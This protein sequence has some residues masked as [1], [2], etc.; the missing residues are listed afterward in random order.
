MAARQCLLVAAT[1]M[2][3]VHARRALH[4]RFDLVSAFS[5]HQALASL[6]S[7]GIDAIVCSI[8]FDESRM[9]DLLT[10]AR[11]L[12]PDTPVVCCRI[13]HSPLSPRAIEALITTVQSLGCR[14][15]VDFN[16]LYR[17]QGQDEADRR[18]CEA[19]VESVAPTPERKTA[20]TGL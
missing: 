12:A 16:E 4:H 15:F 9:F 20:T 10:A 3:Y 8:H 19:V 7:G 5:T 14:Q 17:S 13:L 11:E 6:R 18:L 1:P 2:G